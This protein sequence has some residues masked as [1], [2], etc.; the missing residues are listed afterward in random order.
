M[1]QV[2]NRKHVT[3]QVQVA[4]STAIE[5]VKPEGIAATDLG[6]IDPAVKDMPVAIPLSMFKFLV[7]Q[8]LMTLNS[9]ST[10]SHRAA[11]IAAKLA[12]AESHEEINAIMQDELTGA[13]L[14]DA[15]QNASV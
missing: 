7:I 4:I 8:Y 5:A 10:P 13:L 2:K 11:R 12:E 3:E 1:T 9:F 6:F 14:Q 15:F